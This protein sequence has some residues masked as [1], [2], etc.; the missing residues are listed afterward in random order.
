M[1]IKFPK[2]RPDGSF[3]V[4]VSVR[5]TTQEPQELASRVTGWLDQ[6]VLANRQWKFGDRLLDFFEDFAGAPSCI[7]S[8]P[9]LLTLRFDGR[10]QSKKWWKDWIGVRLLSDLRKAFSEIGD[11]DGVVDCPEAL[12]EDERERASSGPIN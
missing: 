9:G 6:W 1:P 5:V 8:A 3:C 2:R 11:V 10:P 4:L 12:A 7:V